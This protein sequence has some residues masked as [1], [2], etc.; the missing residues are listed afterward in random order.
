MRSFFYFCHAELV[1]YPTNVDYQPTL[2]RKL[3]ST[4]T[5][6]QSTHPLT[7]KPS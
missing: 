7:K 4:N 5:L 2:G 6:H 3:I 1:I